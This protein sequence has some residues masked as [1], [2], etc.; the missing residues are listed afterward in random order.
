MRSLRETIL[1]WDFFVPPA[2]E[3]ILKSIIHRT[4]AWFPSQSMSGYN[5]MLRLERPFRAWCGWPRPNVFRSRGTTPIGVAA[6]AFQFASFACAWIMGCYFPCELFNLNI[7][8]YLICLTESEETTFFNSKPGKII[9]LEQ[10]ISSNTMRYNTSKFLE[11]RN[12][13]TLQLKSKQDPQESY[14][15]WDG[16]FSHPNQAKGCT[17]Y[18]I[19]EFPSIGE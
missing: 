6:S 14:F 4:I 16:G 11:S 10:N 3:T 2:F 15:P 12:H 5:R 8:Q 1:E 7:I 9:S 17:Y 19:Q 13:T 18:W